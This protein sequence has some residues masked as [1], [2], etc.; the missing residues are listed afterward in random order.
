MKCFH[1]HRNCSSCYEF[2]PVDACVDPASCVWRHI[3]GEGLHCV[4]DSHHVVIGNCSSFRGVAITSTCAADPLSPLLFPRSLLEHRQDFVCWGLVHHSSTSNT[5]TPP[6]Y[7]IIQNCK[8][9]FVLACVCVV[10]FTSKDDISCQQRWTNVLG[11]GSKHFS[12]QI[13]Q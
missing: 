11:L 10:F 13:T 7:F 6:A 4:C 2:L 8:N 5:A 1:F 3:A 12:W 9:K